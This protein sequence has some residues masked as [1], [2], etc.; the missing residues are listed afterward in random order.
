M[1]MT[2]VDPIRVSSAHL[3]GPQR[4]RGNAVAACS[5]NCVRPLNLGRT[6]TAIPV[7]LPPVVGRFCVVSLAAFTVVARQHRRTGPLDEDSDHIDRQDGC[8]GTPQLRAPRARTTTRVA[9]PLTGSSTNA[10]V[11]RGIRAGRRSPSENEASRGLELE[12]VE[13]IGRAR[14]GREECAD[15]NDRALPQEQVEGLA[16]RERPPGIEPGAA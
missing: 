2:H 10:H 9:L 7:T 1:I 6:L 4:V 13:T 12:D 8:G 16:R 5:E 3:V 15:R 14:N 11:I